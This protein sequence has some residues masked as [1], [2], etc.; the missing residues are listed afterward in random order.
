MNKQLIISFAVVVAIVAAIFIYREA[1]VSQS[2][3]FNA[4]EKKVSSKMKDPSSAIFRDLE[5]YSAESNGKSKNTT[6]CGYVNSKNTYGAYVGSRMFISTVTIDGYSI[7]VGSVT[8]S[9]SAEQDKIILEMC[10]K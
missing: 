7:E 3:I 9:N 8:I 2:S 1:S 10:K 4:V 5:S 6:V